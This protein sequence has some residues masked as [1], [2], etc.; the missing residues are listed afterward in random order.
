MS[1]I[2]LTGV[3]HHPVMS[4]LVEV[5]CNRTLN[6]DTGFFKTGVAYF[7][8]KM[9]ST[10]RVKI[11]TKDRGE[12]PIN[13]YAMA[14]ATSGYGKTYSVSIL[15]NEFV[16]DFK[17][18]FM[19][20]TM[21]IIA[22]ANLRKIAAERA[23][24]KA[25]DEEAEIAKVEKEFSRLGTYPFSFDSGTAPAVKQLRQMLLMAD[26]GSINLEVDEIGSNLVGNVEVLNVFLE[27]YDQ[28]MV[29]QKL[30]KN[31][32]ENVRNEE[33]DGKTPANMLMF[34]TPNKLFDGGVVEDQFYSQLETGYARRCVFGVGNLGGTK[35][36]PL[37]AQEIFQ[38][39]TDP[40]NKQIID[41]W[42]GAFNELANPDFFGAT[43]VVED[44]VALFLIEYKL[45]C[46][47]LAANMADHEE[48]RK[49]EMAHRYFK[50]LKLAGAY[51]FV[52]QSAAIEMPHMQ[53]A[54]LFVEESGEAFQRIIQ[55]EKTYVKLARYIVSCG[56][57]LTHADLHEALPFYKTAQNARNEM[58]TLAMAWAYRAHTVIEK[59]YVDG[60]EFFRG[61]QLKETDPEK[62]IVSYSESF[63]YDY[64]P[65][66]APWSDFSQLITQPNMHWCNHTFQRNH[67]S[68]DTTIAGFNLVV[69]DIDGGGVRLEYVHELLKEYVFMTHTTKR[70]TEEEHRFRLILPMNYHLEMTEDEYKEFM[71]NLVT[72]LPFEVDAAANQR[73]RKWLTNPDAEIYVNEDGDKLLDVLKFIP[74]TSK[75]EQYRSDYSQIASMDNLERWFAQ[76]IAEGNR[77]NNMLR[78][79]MALVDG[80]LPL[81]EVE[82]RVLEFNAKLNNG[83]REDEIRATIFVS[84]AKKYQP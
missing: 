53:Q 11:S 56:T 18:R 84:V 54:I 49:A 29:K 69:L 36:P 10:M 72:W 15:E 40:R 22:T 55:R 9:A 73:S 68:E 63:A 67:R 34:G 2:D 8:A 25:S 61:K 60:I 76:R 7:I 30:T 62:L 33:I 12:I 78:F 74:R 42:R 83:L 24:S 48:I 20:E 6:P 64:Q 45:Q 57:D 70:H 65:D 80:G 17:R 38:K 21:P 41:K 75:N 4:E 1:L 16:A 32:A 37:T 35:T 44:D 46:E 50:A 5:I 19:M 23:V 31:T 13:M 39:Q 58:M 82:K 47:G 43:I 71:E 27:L 51:A 77:N 59:F 26:C 3:E 52:D 14:L 66:L 28:G 79:A 81:H